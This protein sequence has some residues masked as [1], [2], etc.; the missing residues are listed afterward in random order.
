MLNAERSFA[1]K[2]SFT[3]SPS[4]LFNLVEQGDYLINTENSDSLIAQWKSSSILLGYRADNGWEHF[5]E[6]EVD[7]RLIFTYR[8]SIG[9]DFCPV[10]LRGKPHLCSPSYMVPARPVTNRRPRTKYMV[11]AR[12][13]ALVWVTV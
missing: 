4:L 5:W 2:R 11:Q 6:E 13:L 12:Q 3:V 10:V 9:L 1:L 8:C 7:E